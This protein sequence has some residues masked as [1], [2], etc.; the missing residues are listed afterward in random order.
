[1]HSGIT[2]VVATIMQKIG[3]HTLLSCVYLLNQHQFNNIN[4]AYHIS[5]NKKNDKIS[6]E[7]PSKSIGTFHHSRTLFTTINEKTRKS[8]FH[9]LI[10][11]F[12]YFD[13]C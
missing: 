4:S 3:K 5:K 6:I 10:P 9:G 8:N 11:Y 7:I 1:M 2:I 13:T 12:P